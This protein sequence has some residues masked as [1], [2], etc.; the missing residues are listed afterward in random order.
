MTE[1]CPSCPDCRAPM[2]L[3]LTSWYCDECYPDEEPTDRVMTGPEIDDGWESDLQLP[4]LPLP[5]PR[6]Q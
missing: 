1:G 2:K 5:F 3:L 6:R 4:P